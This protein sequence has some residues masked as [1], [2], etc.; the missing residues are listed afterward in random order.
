MSYSV[1][2][3]FKATGVSQFTSAFKGA[4]RSVQGFVNKNQKTFDSFKQVGTAAVLAGTA[5][6]GGLGFAVKKAADFEGG[7]SKV[8]AISGATGSDFDKLSAKAREMGSKT[9]FSATEAAEGLEYMALAGWDTN[10]M[11]SGLEPVL[12]LAEAGNLD[13]GRASDLVTDSMA[14]MGIE[15]QDLDGYLDKVAATSS[16]ANT[17]IDALME[18]FVIAGGTFQRL[19]VPLEESNAFLGVLANRGTKGAEAGTAINAIMTRLTSTTGPAAEA[20]ENMGIAAFDADGNFRGMET[21]L[22]EVEL[23]M[24]DMNDE[25]RAQAVEMLAGL[26]HGKSFEKMINGLGDEYDELKGSVE[27]SNGALKI[28]RDI[29]KD[30]LQGALE[31]LSSAFEEMAIGIGE[32][33][34]PYVKM[35][36]AAVQGLA[37]WFNSLSEQTKAYIA[38]SAALSAILLLVGGGLMLLIGI[39]PS[40]V[41]GFTALKTVVIAVGGAFTAA[42]LP[43]IAIIATIAL[44]V[45]AVVQLLRTN[46]TFRDNMVIIWESVKTIIMTVLQALMPA[47]DIFAATIMF[48]IGVIMAVIEPVIAVAATFIQWVA[49]I[50]ETHAWI[51]TLI[52]VIA[53]I[54]GVVA[55]AI[56]I[57]MAIGAVIAFVSKVIAV[58]VTVA[59]VLGVVIAFLVSPI[60]LVILAIG[61]LIG[62]VVWL[63]TK[64]EWLGDLLSGV[65]DWMSEKWNSFLG[66]FGMGTKDAADEASESISSTAEKGKEDLGGLATE[67]TASSQELNT[68]FL[69]NMSGMEEGT[70]LSIGNMKDGGV[71]SLDML[72]QQGSAASSTMS[73]NVTTDIAGMTAESSGLLSQL[74][75]SGNIDMAGLNAGVTGEVGGMS[76]KSKA[77]ISAMQTGGSA[78]FSALE[79]NA[80]SS[81]SKTSVDVSSSFGEM[82]SNVDKEL[83]GIGKN[84]KTSLNG[85][86]EQFAQSMSLVNKTMTTSMQSVSRTVAQ[87]MGLITKTIRASFQAVNQ[88]VSSETSKM[89]STA[90][91]SMN[92]MIL[93]YRASFVAIS[94]AIRSGMSSAVSAVQNGNLFIVA[95]VR[96]LNGQLYSAGI[97]AMSGLRS[98][99]NAGSGS[100][101]STARGIANRVS[102]TIKSAL[103][104]KSPSRVMMEIGN[105]VGEGLAIGMEKTARLVDSASSMLATSATPQI[106]GF[107]V[108]SR[109]NDINR[110]AERQLSHTFESNVDVANQPIVIHTTVDLDGNVL[111][112]SVNEVNAKDAA[113]RRFI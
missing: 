1:E 37:D 93:G 19:N 112:T 29:M 77:D 18:A 92:L 104:V 102:S 94:S 41:A 64:F 67:G 42:S 17:D 85:I 52:Q 73:E 76:A 90:T 71:S 74:E 87:E 86:S 34:L 39:I 28:M 13:L 2:A 54:I 81:A 88:V 40:I 24:A 96:S 6:A 60:G 70:I 43:M 91:Q 31:N 38:I 4:E 79:S 36:V 47:F 45:V 3:V 12:H 49:H 59:K 72:K 35:L 98:G 84:A 62:V 55:S 53:A 15:V 61:A 9:S 8:K 80:T 5:V 83:K 7:M 97:H 16:N 106:A 100:V 110:Q 95:N 20:L 101:I 33:L 113:L 63:G 108:G 25:Q 44:V 32:A 82:G 65:A 27:N 30:N 50:I 69:S 11:I 56:A 75:S 23:A 107:N 14:A 10:Q 51:T 46:E 58:L 78:D 89:N 26:N 21:V 68:N 48:L 57:F 111:A 66:F 105:N 109:V 103:K 99:L 22:K